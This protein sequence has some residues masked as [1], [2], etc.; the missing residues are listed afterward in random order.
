MFF[1][2]NLSVIQ[3]TLKEIK[4]DCLSRFCK[5][6]D[7]GSKYQNQAKCLYRDV[8]HQMP[9]DLLKYENEMQCNPMVSQLYDIERFRGVGIHLMPLASNAFY[10]KTMQ[11]EVFTITEEEHHGSE[12]LAEESKSQGFN[13]VSPEAPHDKVVS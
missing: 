13:I 3:L 7:K 2:N 12:E 5:K 8:K 9:E 10:V 11:K 1:L 4:R 6:D